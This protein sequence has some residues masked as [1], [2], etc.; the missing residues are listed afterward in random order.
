MRRK[1]DYTT[2]DRKF[3]ERLDYMTTKHRKVLFVRM[4]PR[5]PEETDPNEVK[6]KI[7]RLVSRL[8]ESQ[9]S[10]GVEIQDVWCREKDTS[11]VPHYHVVVLANGSEVQNPKIITEDAQRLWQS[12]TKSD[13]KGLIDYCSRHRNLDPSKTSSLM[14][15]RPSS[16]A[17]GDELL[18]QQAAFNEAKDK[19]RNRV[20]YLSKTNT[21]GNVQKRE[22]E[23]GASEI[24]K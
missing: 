2:I 13:K 7:S 11:D 15:T 20:A 16:R 9:K 1:K 4:D 10:K 22:R 17:E 21:K 3:Q 5:L 24:P 12:I 14:I 8:K 18:R 23:Y 6:G 19:A